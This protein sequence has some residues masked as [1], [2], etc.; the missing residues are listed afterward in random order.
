MGSGALVRWLLDNNLV[1]EIT[2]LIVPVVLGQGAR[3]FPDAAR[4]LRWT[5][6][7]RE[8]TPK[9]RPWSTARRAPAVCNRHHRPRRRMT[10]AAAPTIERQPERGIEVARR[11][12]D[13]LATMT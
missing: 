7:T 4:T 11:A 3:L 8:P 1:D 13:G 9:A 5:W 2:L 10:P 6:S 12:F